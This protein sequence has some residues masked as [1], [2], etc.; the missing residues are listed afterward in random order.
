[1][2]IKLKLL[3]IRYL[4]ILSMVK[5]RNINTLCLVKIW[6]TLIRNKKRGR[7]NKVKKVRINLYHKLRKKVKIKKVKMKK[8]QQTLFK[9]IEIFYYS[10][11]MND[12]YKS[13]NLIYI[14]THSYYHI[15]ILS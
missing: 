8:S 15:V 10:L 1:M 3:T 6:L 11:L 14:L 12:L 13:L 9:I 5:L 7:I 2:L 4:R